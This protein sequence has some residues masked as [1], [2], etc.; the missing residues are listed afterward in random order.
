[1][2]NGF[3]CVSKFLYS[4]RRTASAGTLLDLSKYEYVEKKPRYI[5][6]DSM[7]DMYNISTCARGALLDCWCVR[8]VVRCW[9]RE[10]ARDAF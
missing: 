10:C 3:C 1:M 6:C 2:M 9:P 8:V 4:G 5:H 7:W